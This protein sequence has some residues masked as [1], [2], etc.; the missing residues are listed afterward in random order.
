MISFSILHRAMKAYT[1]IFVLWGLYRL[2]FR[3]PEEIEETFLKPLVFV[4]AI[5]FVE[6]P[7]KAVKFF[8]EVW[9]HGKWL[10]SMFLGLTFGLIY[11]A[12]YGISSVLTFGKLEFGSD[13]VGSM[14]GSFLGISL[15]TAI[16]EEWV[17]PG[18][19]LRTFNAAFHGAWT[20]RV[21]TAFLFAS[22]HVPILLFWYK[23]TPGVMLF[24]FGLLFLLGIGNTILMGLTKNLLAPVLSHALWGVAIFLFR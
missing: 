16:W 5:L 9:G 20:A 2:I 23:F 19:M 6:R 4:G 10:P 18:Y 12:F 17:F 3:L 8:L 13:V 15:V 1:I 24:Q 22:V 7:K 21:T 11:V 14:W